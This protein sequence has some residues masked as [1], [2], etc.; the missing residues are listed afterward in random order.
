MGR[1]EQLTEDMTA[2]IQ[3]KPVVSDMFKKPAYQMLRV[4][5]FEVRSHGFDFFVFDLSEQLLL[6]Q[7]GPP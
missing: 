1:H 5:S 2:D 4:I 7:H 6:A 3:T